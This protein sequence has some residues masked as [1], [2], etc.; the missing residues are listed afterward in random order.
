MEGTTFNTPFYDPSY[1]TFEFAQASFNT[2]GDLNNFDYTT[3]A[4]EIC[5][6][7]VVGGV[8]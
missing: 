3:Y 7:R 8:E 4:I 5:G 1:F 2:S 6:D